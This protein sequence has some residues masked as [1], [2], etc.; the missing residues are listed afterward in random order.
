MPALLVLPTLLL[1]LLRQQHDALWVLYIILRSSCAN[2]TIV[3][4]RDSS[5][6]HKPRLN[7]LQMPSSSE[8][9]HMIPEED[10]PRSSSSSLVSTPR[11]EC[12]RTFSTSY[13]EVSLADIHDNNDD[14]HDLQPYRPPLQPLVP[15]RSMAYERSGSTSPTPSTS[16]ASSYS[17]LTPTSSDDEL[18]LLK[19]NPRP[20]S[21]R[22]LNIT[23]SNGQTSTFNRTS[24]IE[25]DSD[26]DS[27]SEWYIQEFS[28]MVWPLPP[29]FPKQ[30][31]SRPESIQLQPLLSEAPVTRSPRPPKRVASRT[32]KRGRSMPKEA[33]PPIPTIPA[34]SLPSPSVSPSIPEIVEPLG[35]PNTVIQP[36]SPS[37]SLLKPP[38]RTSIPIDCLPD[39]FIIGEDQSYWS[40]DFDLAIC[41]Q[42]SPALISPMPRRASSFLTIPH[43]PDSPGSM[44]S[45]ASALPH[46]Y[47]GDFDDFGEIE[48]AVDDV[49]FDFSNDAPMRLPLSLPNTPSDLETDFALGLEQ[50]RTQNDTA[51]CKL[52]PPTIAVLDVDRPDASYEPSSSF[53]PTPSISASFDSYYDSEIEAEFFL[54]EQDD[55]L[56]RPVLRSKWSNSTLASVH[57]E[58]SLRGAANKFRFYFGVG[59]LSLKSKQ[60]GKQHQRTGSAG[61][62]SAAKAAVTRA[63][64]GGTYPHR[65]S[66]TSSESSAWS[67][68]ASPASPRTKKAQRQVVIVPSSPSYISPRNSA[69]PM[70]SPV[71]PHY[72]KGKK[73][74]NTPESGVMVIGYG[75][76]GVGK[77][78]GRRGSM[79]SDAESE[80]N[81]GS[82]KRKPIPV[83]MFLRNAADV[84]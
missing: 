68:A 36:R 7:R 77:G 57:E 73:G 48:F 29:S 51:A 44:Y 38:P 27:D 42:P 69:S 40:E 53:P 4:S 13:I 10:E 70:S 75:C 30:P 17:P 23:K 28:K 9:L 37:P 25:P 18:P 54:A 52:T 63:A 83:E 19:M 6:K 76:G 15:P 31:P 14:H 12:K 50:L 74:W 82:L 16:S 20:V 65:P 72:G 60:Q 71:S 22:P 58:P 49:K 80:E 81:G 79:T 34:H 2:P 66:P 41:E 55:T 26:D 64:S 1:K 47:R 32:H 43:F 62:L 46:P 24:F 67:V 61:A 59:S 33:L 35:S 11:S 3:F 56:N 5:L 78:L 8:I 21:I 45:Q 39:D 84:H